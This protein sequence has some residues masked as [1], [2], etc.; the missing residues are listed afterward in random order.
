MQGELGL[1]PAI[2]LPF[3]LFQFY[4]QDGAVD[5]SSHSAGTHV[6]YLQHHQDI[7]C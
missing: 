4:W 6:Q 5:G 3:V 7:Y 1:V 2:I